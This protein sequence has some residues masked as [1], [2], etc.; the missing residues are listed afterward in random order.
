MGRLA[1][2]TP[3]P[4]DDDADELALGGKLDIMLTR[5]LVDSLL[6]VDSER[7]SGSDARR[8]RGLRAVVPCISPLGKCGRE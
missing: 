2:P 3:Q 5:I 1:S 7:C 8:C 4:G 6:L